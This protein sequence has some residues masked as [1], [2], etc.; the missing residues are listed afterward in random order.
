MSNEK[1]GSEHSAATICSVSFSMRE[2]QEVKLSCS[3]GQVLLSFPQERAVVL[4]LCLGQS[5]NLD[6]DR[7]T[8]QETRQ[9]CCDSTSIRSDEIQTRRC[10][11][12]L[13]VDIGRENKSEQDTLL[14]K[15]QLLDERIRLLEL[16]GI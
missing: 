15:R 11:I 13:R 5:N 8:P 1:A 6:L 4:T 2:D 14:W 12:E 3:E 7:Q 10:D 16:T 9:G